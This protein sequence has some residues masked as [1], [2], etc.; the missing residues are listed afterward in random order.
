MTNITRQH[1]LMKATIAEQE[2]KD[3]RHRAELGDPQAQFEI[4]SFLEDRISIGETVLI[5][6]DSCKAF[7]WFKKS[8]EKGNPDG[9]RRMAD[10]LSEGLVTEQNISL[11]IKLYE[12]AIEKG[13][14]SA[15]NNLAAVYRD[16]AEFRKA[17]ELYQLSQK[18]DGYQYSLTVALCHLY[19]IG[20]EPDKNKAFTMLEAIS[21]DQ[22]GGSCQYDVDE[23]NFLL[24]QIYLRGD[25]VPQSL[26][27]AREYLELADSDGDHPSAQELLKVIGRAKS[28]HSLSSNIL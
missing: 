28:S 22:K 14:G 12:K 23:A 18:L 20:T 24:G 17:F 8:A 9:L 7:E 27:L 25:V 16:M 2:W 1:N 10:Y 5:E 4:G 15:A 13:D 19:G 21:N 3:L 6:P 26:D 11:A